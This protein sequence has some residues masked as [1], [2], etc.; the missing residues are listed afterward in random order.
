M[1]KNFLSEN[2][3]LMKEWDWEANE[4]LNP[5]EITCGSHKKVWWKCSKCGFE[6]QAVVRF[7]VKGLGKCPHCS[8]KQLD[9]GLE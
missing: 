8:K 4:G 6:R 5:N 9:L 3:E 7:R 1:T 2:T